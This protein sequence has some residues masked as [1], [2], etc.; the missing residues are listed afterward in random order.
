MDRVDLDLIARKEHIDDIK[1]VIENL[2]EIANFLD[3]A[4]KKRASSNNAMQDKLDSILN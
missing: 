1:F 4:I 3:K 2:P